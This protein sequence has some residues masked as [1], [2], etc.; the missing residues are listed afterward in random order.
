ML[1]GKVGEYNYANTLKLCVKISWAW[2]K[3]KSYSWV[4]HI[5]ERWNLSSDTKVFKQLRKIKMQI[6]T[7][8]KIVT[9]NF[10]Q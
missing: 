9:G 4:L 8:K 7:I 1:G 5:Y 2:S 3:I 10:S 6:Q